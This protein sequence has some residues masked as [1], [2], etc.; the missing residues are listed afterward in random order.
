[1]AFSEKRYGL[2]IVLVFADI[3]DRRQLRHSYIGLLEYCFIF[4]GSIRVLWGAEGGA[5]C[6]FTLAANYMPHLSREFLLSLQTVES[7][8]DW[9][10][11][12][13]TISI[14]YLHITVRHMITPIRIYLTHHDGRLHYVFI[15]TLY[16][17]RRHLPIFMPIYAT[18]AVPTSENSV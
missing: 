14:V 7:E 1:M 2:L 6:G 15:V 11:F 4:A 18:W 8:R 12:V 13:F 16:S 17:R 9:P 3:A 10:V 5:R